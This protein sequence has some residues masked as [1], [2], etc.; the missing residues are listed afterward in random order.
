MTSITTFYF[1][2]VIGEKVVNESGKVIGKLKDLIV[3]LNSERPKVLA[4]KIQTDDGL[5]IADFSFIKIEKI[6]GH[7][8]IICHELKNIVLDENIILTVGKYVLDR[9]IVDMDGR[10]LVRVNDL[11][12]AV[13]SSSTHLIAAD[14]GVEG[15]L[16]RLGIAKPLKALLKPFNVSI[17]SHLIL[18]DEVQAV[19]FG[20]EGIKL[21]KDYSS[22]HK[23]HPSDLAD[24]IEDMDSNTQMAVF[25]SLNDEQAT[26]VLEELEPEAQVSLL[27]ML[28]LEKAADL[29]EMMPADE[30]ADILEELND[31]KAE[32][33]LNEMEAEASA[34][35]RELM[36]YPDN[37][38]GSIMSTDFICFNEYNTVGETIDALRKEKPES[39]AIYYLYIID[40]AGKLI[41]N[42][43]LRDLIVSD[44]N[45]KLIEIM[46]EDV[47]SVYDTDSIESLGEMISKYNL[48]AIP[49]IAENEEL[50][51]MVI[52]NDVIH[53]LL[54][55]RRKRT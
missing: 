50:L 37:S 25:N 45:R 53:N 42:V 48:L 35:V 31:E 1:S 5:K 41:A 34:E 28:P 24:I 18:W 23:L 33:L 49:V 55:L 19:D 22:L 43:S 27:E 7:Y 2:R 40:N 44:P 54:K 30:A 51:G 14:V 17:P 47:V 15:L 4:A 32:E 11:R 46:K 9:Q 16:R 20:N 52:I 10:K 29:L 21:S 13:I 38:V 8:K 3:E 6:K 26:D 12:L 39:D 36:E